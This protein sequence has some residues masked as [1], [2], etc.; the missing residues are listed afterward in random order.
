MATQKD[1]IPMAEALKGVGD[2]I[3]NQDTE[4][5]AIERYTWME[6]CRAVAG[7][8]LDGNPRFQTDTFLTACGYYDDIER[9]PITGLAVGGA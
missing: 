8:F 5:Q 4:T 7:S 3:R 6:T 1:F 2:R 9:D